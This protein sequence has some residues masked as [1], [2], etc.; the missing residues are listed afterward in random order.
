MRRHEGYQSYF[1]SDTPDFFRFR[2]SREQSRAAAERLRP[3]AAV[4]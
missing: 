1:S 4:Q 2:L 3:A